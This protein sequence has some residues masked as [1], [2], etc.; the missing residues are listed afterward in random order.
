[1]TRIRAV[2]FDIDDTLYLERDYVLSG[3]MAVG[4]WAR[5]TL[6]L[7]A[8]GD[9]CW[10]LFLA[11]VRGNIFDRALMESG[12]DPQPELAKHM[13]DVYRGHT[14]QIVLSS[15]SSRYLDMAAGVTRMAAIT[16]GPTGSQRAKVQVLGLERWL[17][18]IVLT[19]ELGA[20]YR[21][22]S[23]LSFKLVQE[24]LG[25]ESRECIYV[26]D[27]PTKDF[28]GPAALGWQTCRVRRSGSLHESLVSGS[29]VQLEVKDLLEFQRV[30]PDLPS[31]HTAISSPTMPIDE[32]P[33]GVDHA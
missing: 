17:D 4:T 15:D 24:Q 19:E 9:R 6:D 26:A 2:I 27:N 14:P 5:L 29:D 32:Q 28:R 8:F 21:K 22:P 25:A 13:R 12:V 18:P 23:P 30:Y 3:F 1:M 31:R 7:P 10:S 33:K 16:D 11:G 20:P